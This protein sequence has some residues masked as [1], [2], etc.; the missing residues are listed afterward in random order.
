MIFCLLVS[1]KSFSQADIQ[2]KKD[3]VVTLSESQARRVI[4]D[5]IR[6]EALILVSSELEDR[7]SI[8]VK[9][10][11][12]FVQKIIVKDSII[13]I[14]QQYIDIQD[15]VINTKKP[16]RFNGFIGIQ[17]QQ[18]SI[19]NPILYFQTEVEFRKFNIGAR[20]FVKPD[21]FAGYGLIIEYK[22]F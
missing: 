12:V 9:K 7:I 14:Q 22:I 5:L 11:N 1:F 17:T 20:V 13:S 2:I 10:E 16:L 8:L 19:E 3:S 4:K 21:S 15:K 18:I 6:Y